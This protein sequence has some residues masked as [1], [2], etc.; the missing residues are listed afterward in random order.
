MVDKDEDTELQLNMFL[1]ELRNGNFNRAME[2][3]TRRRSVDEHGR[4]IVCT[5]TLLSNSSGID[6]FGEEDD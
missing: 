1:E 5:D 2:Y 4:E 3:M 6:W